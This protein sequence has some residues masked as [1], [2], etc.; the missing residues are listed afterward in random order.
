MILL[1]HVGHLM[2]ARIFGELGTGGKQHLHL[3][4]GFAVV[5]VLLPEVLIV[6]IDGPQVFEVGG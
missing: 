1:K 2:Q 5:A 4:H 3:V 6:E